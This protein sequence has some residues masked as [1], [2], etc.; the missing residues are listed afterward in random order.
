M[1]KVFVISPALCTAG[2]ATNLGGGS[3]FL[4]LGCSFFSLPLVFSSSQPVASLPLS[5]SRL[6][7]SLSLSPRL[8][9]GHVMAVGFGGRL[10]VM[11]VVGMVGDL[12]V[13]L[14]L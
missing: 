3:S 12:A 5:S 14:G 8:G 10:W 7:L 13:G 1:A 4:P 9:Q 11:E 6:S 2:A